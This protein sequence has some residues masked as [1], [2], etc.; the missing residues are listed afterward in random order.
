M[1]RCCMQIIAAGRTFSIFAR[2]GMLLLHSLLLF[3]LQASPSLFSLP[4]TDEAN[5]KHNTSVK[6]DAVRVCVEKKTCV[7]HYRV[8]RHALLFL[9]ILCLPRC[10][11]VSLNRTP[12]AQQKVSESS[13]HQAARRACII[14][15][16]Q[17]MLSSSSPSSVSLAV[18]FAPPL[19]LRFGIARHQY[20]VVKSN[21][22]KALPT[23]LVSY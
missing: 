22:S 11:V 15:A 8:P 18:F 19:R 10:L 16:R 7:W 23:V 3:L 5:I 1:L 14:T 13:V 20:Y 4:H 2:Q 12:S 9:A 21:V 17:G 6:V